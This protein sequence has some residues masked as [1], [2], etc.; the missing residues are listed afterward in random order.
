MTLISTIKKA[1]LACALL[2]LAGT[3]MAQLSPVPKTLPP[4]FEEALPQIEQQC[5]RIVASRYMEG[6]LMDV[7]EKLPGWEGYPVE[8]WAYQVKDGVTGEMKDAKVYML[9]AD[10]HKLAQWVATTAWEARHSLDQLYTNAIINRI[11]HQSNGQ[12]PVLGMVYEDMDGNGQFSY[13]FKDGVTC[14]FADDAHKIGY[15]DPTPEMIDF[16]VNFTDDDLDTYTGRYGRIISTTR[17]D[18]YAYGGKEDVGRSDTRN[19]RSLSWLKTVRELYQQAWNSPY[20]QLMIAA[21]MRH[22]DEWVDPKLAVQTKWIRINQ[23]GYLPKDVKVAVLMS[24]GQEPVTSFELVDVFSGKTIYKSDKV[25]P[26]G[27]WGEMKDT[28]RLDFSDFQEQGSYYVR[29]AETL[30]PAFPI[31]GTVYNGTADFVLNYMR[32]QR[33][34]YNPFQRDSCHTKDGYIRYHPTKEGQYIDVTGGWHDAADLL[35]YTTTSANAIYQMMLAYQKHPEAFGDSHQANGLEGANGI[36]DIVDEIYWGLEWL[37]K[38]NPAPGEFYNQIAD[39][40]DHIGT[41]MPKD[42]PAD[43]GW[44]RN[45]GRPVYFID[46]KP[47]QR[48][49]FM[50]ATMGM[51]STVGKFASDFALGSQVLEPFYPEFAKKIAAKASDAFLKGVDMPGHTQTVSVISPYIYEEANWVDDMEL[52]A[53]EMYRLTGDSDFLTRAVEYGRREPVT[54]WMGADSA[55]HYQWYPFMNMGHYQVAKMGTPKMKKE[56]VRNMRAGL[57]RVLERAQETGNPFLWGVPGIWCSN[58]LTTALLT[59]SILYREL[60]GSDEYA[61][62]EAALRDWLFGCNPWGTSMIVELP[63]GGVY[64]H[65]THSNWVFEGV[66]F[67]TGGLVDGPVYAGIFNSLKGVNLTDDMP[68]VDGNTYKGFQPGDVVY[69]DNTHDYSTNEP[70]MDGTASLTFPLAYYQSQGAGQTGIEVDRNVYDEGGINRG[71]PSQKKICLVFTADTF[72]DG[73]DKIISTLR[74]ENIHG[75]FFFTGNTYNLYPDII[76]RLLSDGHYLG[77]HSCGHL[78]YASWGNRDSLLVTK[79][80][81]EKD[82]LRSYAT[83][84]KFGITKDKAPYFIPPYEY[85]NSTIASWAKGLGLQIINFTPGTGSN[86]DYT[87]P[88]MEDGKYRSSKYLYDELMK[89]EKEHTLNGHFLMIHFGTDERRTDKFYDRLPRIIKEL[90]KRGYRFVGVEEMLN[91]NMK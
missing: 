68:N 7:N 60:T 44:G 63:K 51:A 48:G 83:M 55:R 80:E 45:N 76:R 91:L 21:A 79:D 31:N 42:D 30:S 36:P 28:W 53:I 75:G 5:Q 14:Y 52:G 3:V 24:R 25:T 9:N 89:Y 74:K 49:K 61:Y 4:G 56:F 39:D 47:Q 67:P 69:H 16:C 59:Q 22:I 57:Q 12:F 19:T 81:F 40:R 38:M 43:Y 58:N 6:T 37:D 34:G 32:Q 41:K 70:T 2:T 66:G 85:F 23:L 1:T 29:V 8:L 46:G 50:N 35:Q 90:R 71:D 77:S 20:N 87:Y 54:P 18:Y 26:M 62:M 13:M 10:A 82:I 72:V 84:A 15:K 88:G 27:P 17:E 65:A 64:P 78:L 86:A 73:A 11:I 33:C